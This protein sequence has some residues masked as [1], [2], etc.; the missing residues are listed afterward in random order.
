MKSQVAALMIG[1]LALSTSSS[2]HRYND[3]SNVTAA[4]DAPDFHG[5]ITDSPH[6]L[7]RSHRKVT[8]RRSGE[9]QLVGKDFTNNRGRWRIERPDANGN[10]Y[11]EI[12]GIRKGSPPH[13]HFCRGAIS[14]VVRV[15]P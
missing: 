8:L 13:Q 4:Y 11:A 9:G 5:R 6:R 1:L 15:D 10:Y 7:C 2:A 3:P 12:T 14:K